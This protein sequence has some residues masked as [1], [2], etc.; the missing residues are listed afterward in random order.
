LEDIGN[1]L[2]GG[3]EFGFDVLIFCGRSG[4]IRLPQIVSVN[5]HGRTDPGMSQAGGNRGW[6]EH[7]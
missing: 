1:F 3:P 5:P 2:Y 4:A 6:L 7:S